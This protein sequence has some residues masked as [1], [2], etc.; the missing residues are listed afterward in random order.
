MNKA[1]LDF[2]KETL[3]VQDTVK[4]FES[5]NS[6]IIHTKQSMT[7]TLSNLTAIE[8]SKNKLLDSESDNSNHWVGT[9]TATRPILVSYRN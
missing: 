4:S 6:S 1:K 5:I 9:D 3:Q 8:E 7:E 2:D